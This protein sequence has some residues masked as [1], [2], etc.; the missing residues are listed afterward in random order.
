MSELWKL[1]L[2]LS[3]SGTLLM[4]LLAAGKR[5]WKNSFSKTWQ[6]YIW[7][8]VAARLLLPVTAPLNLMGDLMQPAE[9]LW[10]QA[11]KEERGTY[12]LPG[13]A[14]PGSQE[15]EIAVPEGNSRSAA[16][17]PIVQRLQ[18]S[19]PGI[20]LSMIWLVTALLL[21]AH[22]LWAWR[23]FCTKLRNNRVPVEN[24]VI[25]ESLERQKARLGISGKVPVYCNPGISSPMLAGVLK[26]CIV[27]PE[28]EPV[29]DRTDYILLHELI[30]LKR[31]DLLY[32]WL[33]Q[34]CICLHWFNPFVRRLEKETGAACELACD[35]AVLKMLDE[36]QRRSYGDTLL[37]A[38][39]P[40]EEQKATAAMLSEGKAQMKERLGAIMGY[41]KITA[42]KKMTACLAA[43]LIGWCA[44]SAGAYAAAKPFSSVGTKMPAE[45]PAGT[46]NVR[47]ADAEPADRAGQ[48]EAE[49]EN[50]PGWK[51][52]A[53]PYIQNIYYEYPYL[54]EIGWNLPQQKT[55]DFTYSRTVR[56]ADGADITC[57]FSEKTKQFM[58]EDAVTD[59]FIRLYPK[60][61]K[62]GEQSGL[63][64]E[65]PFIDSIRDV[66]G[67]TA[68]ELAQE[69]YYED[70]PAV[71]SAVFPCLEDGEK[72]SY[73]E[74][75]CKEGKT[76]FFSVSLWEAGP[77]ELKKI[78]DKAWEYGNT[79]FYSITLDYM[80]E[81]ELE[82]LAAGACMERETA[83]FSVIA[84]KLSEDSKARLLKTA[85]K[86][87]W[88]A[89]Y[90]DL[91]EE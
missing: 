32:K 12:R 33:V 86:E 20:W 67:K 78:S 54:M 41:R 79:G 63:A 6:Y 13:A 22:K 71:F 77:G 42:G 2:S 62:L 74:L 83:R 30:H 39:R 49:P 58:E 21:F 45:A 1:V 18:T 69:S 52:K 10:M 31:H 5:L 43:V 72:E 73:W 60:L 87:R 14:G 81:E 59:T 91:L 25:L 38:M 27:L 51:E 28:A 35:E 8:V 57:F 4:L 34:L 90:I 26:P 29:Q 56:L 7:L 70:S 3:L 64:V 37:S 46:M 68:A 76:A 61:Q 11:E 36:K 48:E 55:A 85:E 40:R 84:G 24:K 9:K 89:F 17:S 44:V 82:A 80:K 50:R 19:S 65:A 15:A 16:E 47:K 53:A 23:Q 66:S 88:G 75:F